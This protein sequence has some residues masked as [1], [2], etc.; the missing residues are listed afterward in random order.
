MEKFI[1]TSGK[2]K[3]MFISIFK[4]G[5]FKSV[6]MEI[7][8]D[9]FQAWKEEEGS[10]FKEGRKNLYTAN[11][12]KTGAKSP[13]RKHGVQAVIKPKLNC[14]LLFSVMNECIWSASSLGNKCSLVT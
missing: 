14:L 13:A 3:R 6:T 12:N 1:L 7:I 5:N 2:D 10:W 9:H 8:P 11:E 4:V